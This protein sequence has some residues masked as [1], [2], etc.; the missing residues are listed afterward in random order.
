MVLFNFFVFNFIYTVLIYYK[1]LA[2]FAKTTCLEFKTH[3]IQSCVLTLTV[4]F[5]YSVGIGD[6]EIS[7]SI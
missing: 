1:C 3:F 4:A 2:C 7:L 5:W 6:W